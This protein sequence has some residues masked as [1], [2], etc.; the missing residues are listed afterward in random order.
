MSD[1]GSVD[2]PIQNLIASTTVPWV[3]LGFFALCA[4]AYMPGTMHR[5]RPNSLLPC[6]ND[7]PCSRR[8][9]GRPPASGANRSSTGRSFPRDLAP[10]TARDQAVDALRNRLS[11]SFWQERGSRMPPDLDFSHCPRTPAI[12]EETCWTDWVNTR[13]YKCTDGLFC[14]EPKI[15]PGCIPDC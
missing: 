3:N 1:G 10:A 2:H 7:L 11:N 5:F 9:G 4:I 14:V 15:C 8:A 6:A 13:N 12:R